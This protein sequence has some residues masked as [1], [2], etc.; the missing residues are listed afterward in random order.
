MG[1]N[2]VV[3]SAAARQEYSLASALLDSGKMRA[4]DALLVQLRAEGHKVLL[5]SQMTA[6]MGLLGDYLAFRKF[7]FLRLDG[8]SSI[9]ERSASGPPQRTSSWTPPSL[10]CTLIPC[11]PILAARHCRLIYALAGLPCWC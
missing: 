3:G 5:F 10:Q 7:R 8:S 6:M 1:H 9:A 11:S 2:R 4:L